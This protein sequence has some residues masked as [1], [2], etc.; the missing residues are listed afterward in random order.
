MESSAMLPCPF[1]GG[2]DVDASFASTLNDN[3]EPGQNAGCMNCG[4]GGPDATSDAEAIAAWNARPSGWLS[5]EAALPE[6]GEDE[7]YYLHLSNGDTCVGYLDFNEGWRGIE[8]EAPIGE[9][10]NDAVVTHWRAVDPPPVPGTPE[11]RDG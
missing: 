2:S 9:L 10:F 7:P 4:A 11:D 6:A 5:V 1:C 3:D 8:T